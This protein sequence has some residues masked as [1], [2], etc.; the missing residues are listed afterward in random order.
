MIRVEMNLALMKTEVLFREVKPGESFE[1]QSQLLACVGV[2]ASRETRMLL[3]AGN[4]MVAN[5]IIT[6]ILKDKENVLEKSP[7]DYEWCPDTGI[8][9]VDRCLP[10]GS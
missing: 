4:S 7:G 6:K 10:S 1:F 3:P 9:I 2:K 8:V 5:F